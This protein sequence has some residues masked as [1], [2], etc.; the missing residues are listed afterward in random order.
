MHIA[1]NSVFHEKTKHIKIDYYFICQQVFT[2]TVMIHLL[3]CSS[4]S[5]P[6]LTFIIYC[7]SIS[8]LNEFIDQLEWKQLTHLCYHQGGIHVGTQAKP[9][10]SIFSNC[11]LI[12]SDHFNFDT[13]VKCSADSLGAIMPWRVKRWQVTLVMQTGISFFVDPS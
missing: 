1:F 5:C 6:L 2:S 4:R 3:M 10:A 11:K 12:S 13:K 7:K 9:A 8:F